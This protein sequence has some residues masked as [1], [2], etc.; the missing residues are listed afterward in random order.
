MFFRLVAKSIL[1]RRGRAAVAVLALL[2][3]SG[4]AAAMLSVYYDASQK[5]TRELRAY[6]AN[7]MVTAKELGNE[8]DQTILA[9]FKRAQPSTEIVA[10]AP[11]LYEVAAARSTAPKTRS[12]T[13]V[14]TGTDFEQI[15]K[16]IEAG[17]N[18]V[19]AKTGAA[20]AVG[21]TATVVKEA[22]AAALEH[23]KALAAID[24][25]QATAQATMQELAAKAKAATASKKKA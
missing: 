18:Q 4:M 9:D 10:A 8:I 17:K 6:G 19:T 12:T 1:Y 14:L 16:E 21:Q 23:E 7:I 22:L 20:T 2:V 24:A 13:L 3:G 5:M 25:A 15:K 11:Y